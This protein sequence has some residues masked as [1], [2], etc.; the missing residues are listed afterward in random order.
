MRPLVVHTLCA[1]ILVF[2]GIVACQQPPE[3]APREAASVEVPPMTGRAAMFSGDRAWE[4][5]SAL[6][7]IG[8]RVIDTPGHAKARDYIREQLEK[9]K[10]DVEIDER[11]ILAPSEAAEGEVSETD[12]PS[13]FIR[14]IS[15]TIPGQLS[16]GSILLIA[17]YDTQAFD[18]FDF[19]GA[20]DGGSGAAVL[21]ELSRVIAAEPL[22]YATELVFVDAH[23]RFALPGIA[24]MR[25]KGAGMVQLA[26]AKQEQGVSDI[27][28]VVY[29]N[30]IGDAD[31]QIVRD[32]LSHR[33]YREEFF[34]AAGRLGHEGAFGPDAPYQSS[35]LKH[36]ALSAIGLR[37]IVSIVDTTY[38]GDEPPGLYAGTDQDTLDHCS[39]ESLNA[40]GGVVLEGLEAISAWL[41]KIERFSRLPR[42]KS[43]VTESQA[44][45]QPEP[46]PRPE[47]EDA[48]PAGDAT[49]N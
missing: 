38:G 22:P 19:I 14:N 27:H 2:G 5:L 45:P 7:Q 29:I 49:P 10:L 42:E 16:S 30:R 3:L 8:P 34:S 26:L 44:E 31:L 37:R 4:D 25:H 15:A 18:E 1:A 20:N 35:G 23:A 40:V 6:T 17:P 46:Q 24:G 48:E 33:I 21:L 32:L 36:P 47:S 41:I 39:P 43:A 12:A 13:L 9:L 28:L 11:D